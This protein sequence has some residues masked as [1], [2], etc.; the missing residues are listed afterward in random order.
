M[1]AGLTLTPKGQQKLEAAILAAKQA[2][3]VWAAREVIDLRDEA[4]RRAPSSEE[5]AKL[6]SRGL[7]QGGMGLGINVGIGVFGTPDGDR[8]LRQGDQV[9]LR[10]AITTDPIKTSDSGD[11]FYAGVGSSQRINEKTGFYWRTR[12]RGIIG[13]TEPFNRNYLRAVEDGGLVWTV[14]PRPDNKNRVLEP[15][16]GRVT[17]E[18]LKTI[19]PFRMFGGAFGARKAGMIQRAADAVRTEVRREGLK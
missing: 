5:E 2:V 1:P 9:S 4:A 8:F 12:R 14:T 16:D 10:E 18:M 11:R 15:E 13:P 19:P 7:A 3:Q 17:R 6:L